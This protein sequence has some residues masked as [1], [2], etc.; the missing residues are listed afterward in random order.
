MLGLMAIFNFAK[1]FRIGTLEAVQ[2]GIARAVTDFTRGGLPAAGCILMPVYRAL[3]LCFRLR[4]VKK[5]IRGT[6]SSALRNPTI[7]DTGS[8]V[9]EIGLMH[10]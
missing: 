6:N 10:A 7:E 5:V 1:V 4:A 3:C 2:V 8:T 9:R